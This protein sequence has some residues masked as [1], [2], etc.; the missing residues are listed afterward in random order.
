[1]GSEQG[2]A[3][4]WISQM[5]KYCEIHIIT[6]EE[7]R[8]QIENAI[9]EI[10]DKGI[11]SALDPNRLVADNLIFYWN[12][13]TQTVRNMCW[14]QGDYRFY[15]YYKKWQKKT[16]EIANEIVLREKIDLIH[17]L[18][19]VGFREP[20][21][22][23]K[24]ESVPF[25]WGPMGGMD[26]IP[27]NYIRN[28]GYRTFVKVLLKR[29]VNNW[30]IKHHKRVKAA[31]R[32]ADVLLGATGKS[33]ENVKKYHRKDII[34]MNETGCFINDK[35]ASR[36]IVMD[37]DTN[38]VFNIIWVGRFIPTKK[39]DM[40]LEAVAILKKR[41]EFESSHDADSN[42][43]NSFA[44]GGFYNSGDLT[45]NFHIVGSCYD[46]NL[47]YY[48]DYATKLGVEDVCI[49][50][51]NI[52]N[53]EVQNMMRV[54]DVFFFTSVM[55]ATST[56]VME[57]ITNNLPIV[58]F[59]ICGMASV[60]TDKIGRKIFLS[61]PKQSAQEF[62]DILYDLYKNQHELSEMSANCSIRAQELSWD[63]KII[64]A[65]QIYVD[66]ISN[67]RRT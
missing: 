65:F 49:W 3:W 34:L 13:V 27:I 41:I 35:L 24:I 63:N 7:Y 46:G 31:I 67:F 56:V 59:D 20:G 4:N 36:N 5:A 19:M 16:L 17:Q 66:A 58:C 53:D 11:R 51:G 29:I 18:N 21:F 6:E 44:D 30:Q 1:M 33:I 62:A 28:I 50:H 37:D 32:R 23:W 43:Y 42:S 12:P 26:N 8:L 25:V 64:K 52:P 39:L 45:L 9:E 61:N 38:H 55:E 60:V 14:N 47:G 10:K 57:A 15:Y 40:A 22:L 2:M 54:S 48:H